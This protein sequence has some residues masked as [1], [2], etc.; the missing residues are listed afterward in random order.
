[1][2]TFVI[3]AATRRRG[4]TQVEEMC[5][6]LLANPVIERA[7]SDHLEADGRTVSV[8]R[9]RRPLPRLEL[10]ARRRRGAR[11]SR[12]RRHGRARLARRHGARRCRRGRAPRRVRAR[13][14][15]AHR[16]A[17]ALLAGDGR[18]H[19]VRRRGW[20]GGRYLQR[21]PGAHRGG[22][23]AGSAPPQ[24]RPALH[25]RSRVEVRGR[26][27]RVGAD[28]RRRGSVRCCG[29]RSTTTRGTTPVTPRRSR[30]SSRTARS[31]FATSTTRT[32]RSATSP[33]SPIGAATSSG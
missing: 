23:A 26:L 20:T 3:E 21:L 12:C 18:G 13:R 30:R 27:D 33:G 31:S 29:C 5:A 1:M 22:P 10:R 15:P 7:R 19:G 9:R 14:L 28:R 16:R 17:G 25:L 24:R 11:A 8:P 4:A 2:I 6:R 32:A